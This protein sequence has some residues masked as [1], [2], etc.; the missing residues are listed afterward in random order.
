[1]KREF[2]SGNVR[3]FFGEVVATLTKMLWQCRRMSAW[4]S[5]WWLSQ[6]IRMFLKSLILLRINIPMTG[7]FWPSKMGE[8]RCNLRT[9]WKRRLFIL[10]V[11]FIL[12]MRGARRFCPVAWML[13]K[14]RVPRGSPCW[15]LG[16]VKRRWRVMAIV[17]IQTEVLVRVQLRAPVVNNLLTDF[18]VG[19]F[20][21]KYFVFVSELLSGNVCTCKLRGVNF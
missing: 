4:R 6:S 19:K 2:V 20:W 10:I 3:V 12:R 16:F 9:I 8:R 21:N 14:L 18:S 1:M 13:W 15:G 7:N 5:R 17:G 11:V